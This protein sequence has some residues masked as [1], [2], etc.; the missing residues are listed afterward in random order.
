MKPGTHKGVNRIRIEEKNHKH[1]QLLVRCSVCPRRA[2]G[3]GIASRL[4]SILHLVILNF[5]SRISHM[6]FSDP[7]TS[8]QNNGI[9]SSS[10]SGVTLGL[11]VV[12][13]LVVVISVVC[14]VWVWKRRWILPCAGL[15]TLTIIYLIT[16][17]TT[18]KYRCFA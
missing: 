16:R 17:S 14:F 5:L 2:V 10:A 13:A 6:L 1:S 4:R 7:E 11:G 12:L 18:T 8:D 3:H 9:T 15:V